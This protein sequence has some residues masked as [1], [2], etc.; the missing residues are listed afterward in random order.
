MNENDENDENLAKREK[1]FSSL[2]SQ[3]TVGNGA[4]LIQANALFS[5]CL[6]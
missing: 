4:L 3:F 2:Q 1:T 5:Q 6:S